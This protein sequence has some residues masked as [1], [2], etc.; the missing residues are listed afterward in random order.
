MAP[1]RD[2]SGASRISEEEVELGFDERG[3]EAEWSAALSLAGMTTEQLLLQAHA[4][5]TQVADQ[6]RG[7]TLR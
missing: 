6:Q 1:A 3:V 7:S 4:F 2:S 5:A